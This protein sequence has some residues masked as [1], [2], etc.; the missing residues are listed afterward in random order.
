MT[1]GRIRE[2][3]EEMTDWNMPVG[4]IIYNEDEY[5]LLVYGQRIMERIASV[6][7]KYAAGDVLLRHNVHE[8][9]FILS[10]DQI[11]IAYDNY[12]L[13]Q[14]QHQTMLDL[15]HKEAIKEA[16][17]KRDKAFQN[18]QEL[19]ERL[20]ENW[21]DDTIFRNWQNAANRVKKYTIRKE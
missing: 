7:I 14:T 15:V 11:L 1:N 19:S 20:I 3:L 16:K 17:A 6:C 13:E 18:F 8:N 4:K 10:L 2:I 12:C 5:T 21:N 9:S